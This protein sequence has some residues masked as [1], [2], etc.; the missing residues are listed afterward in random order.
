MPGNLNPMDIAIGTMIDKDLKSCV[1]TNARSACEC[2]SPQLRQEF[3]RI[4]QEGIHR[5]ERL[6]NL[7]MQK[8]AYVPARIDHQTIQQMMPQLQAAVQGINVTATGGA[9]SPNAN[10]V[11]A[12]RIV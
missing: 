9:A 3:T 2:T 1:A 12:P 8:G 4:S 5:Q 10:N 11:T 6:S 7:L